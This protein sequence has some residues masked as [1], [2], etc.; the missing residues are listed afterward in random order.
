MVL[1]RYRS[2]ADPY[3][4]PI[5]KRMVGVHPDVLS[6][7]A[8]AFA[9][10]AGASFWAAGAINHHLL[11]LAFLAIALNSVLDALDGWVARLAGI[12]SKRGDFF[13]SVPPSQ[14]GRC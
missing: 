7:L 5:A 13:S 6:W 12:A 8:F 9:V 3:L 4:T 2:M 10:L 1:N 11:L 14:G